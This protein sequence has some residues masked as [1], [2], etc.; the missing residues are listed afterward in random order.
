MGADTVD[1]DNTVNGPVRRNRRGLESRRRFITTAIEVL[2]TDGPAGASVNAIAKQAGATF[3]TIQHQ[4][5]DVDGAWA[6]VVDHLCVSLSLL[7][8]ERPR[9]DT[10]LRHRVRTLI[11]ALWAG[12]GSSTAL[13]AESLRLS[14][15]RDLATLEAELPKT[16]EAL[17][18][19]DCAWQRLWQDMFVDLPVSAARLRQ[20]RSYV[21]GALRG[22]RMEAQMPG[23][24]DQELA[25]RGLINAT[26]AYLEDGTST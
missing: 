6:A 2:A 1:A 18:R 4:F 20:V 26:I 24:A 17:A 5:G 8:V 19:F 15:P 22:L 21:P 16:A 7:D 23:Y 9:P 11:K 14:L 10:T 13:A 3:G 25:V 12:T